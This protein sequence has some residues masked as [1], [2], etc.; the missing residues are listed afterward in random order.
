[1]DIMT[2][3]EGY[4]VQYN[5]RT[6]V[7]SVW[8]MKGLDLERFCK[9][10]GIKVTK[11]IMTGNIR[12]A[13]RKDVTVSVTGL[14]FNTP[15][16]LVFEYI[17]KF[18]GIIMNSSVIY[19]KFV[20]GPFKGKKSGERKYQVDFTKSSKYMGTYHFLDGSKIR[21]FYRGNVKT[22]GRCHG[23][24]RMCLGKGIAKDCQEAGGD[25][26]HLTEHMKRIWQDIGFNP[27]SFELPHGEENDDEKDQPIAETDRFQRE[28]KKAPV[29]EADRVRFIGLTIANINL[30][31]NDEDIRQFVADYVSNEI[32]ADTIN[33]VREKKKAVVSI[34][35]SLTAEI[36]HAA[37]AKINFKDCKIKFF[38]K[39]LYCRPLRDMTPEKPAIN[40]DATVAINSPLSPSRPPAEVGAKSKEAIKK[41]PGLPPAAQ[42]KA[43]ERQQNRE[44]KDKKDKDKKLKLKEASAKVQVG[45]ELSE[46]QAKIIKNVSAFNILMKAQQF[47]GDLPNPRD[48]RIPAFCSPDPWK[49]RFVQQLSNE[50][51]RLSFGGSSPSLADHTI[52]Y[53][54]ADDRVNKRGAEHL[55][56]PCSPAK[57]FSELKKNRSE[58]KSVSLSSSTS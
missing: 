37:M 18:G 6:S 23:T 1:M 49:S 46:K 50:S 25:R 57:I 7:I 31:V 38:G 9:E 44:K 36:I 53:T 3:M 16:S 4:Q 24:P 20:E 17:K 41:I 55:S 12:P 35:Q 48:G 11:G 52:F 26:V 40:I 19:T 10:E 8:A 13:G 15:D 21:I 54:P 28:E 14:D 32:E 39:P 58:V 30:D 45:D 56:S 29:N 47:Q 43:I 51:R 33:I 42:A 5:G 27:S 22:C 2:Q 34:Q